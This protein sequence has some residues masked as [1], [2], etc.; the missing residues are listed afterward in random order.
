MELHFFLLQQRE[1]K[2]KNDQVCN[3]LCTL[4]KVFRISLTLPKSY[5]FTSHFFFK[6]RWEYYSKLILQIKYFVVVQSLSCVQ[7]FATPW[8]KACQALLSFTI[9][10]TSLKFMSIESLM[11]FDRPSIPNVYFSLIEDTQWG[12]NI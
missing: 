6:G 7:I 4:S 12:F 2:K 9:S 11:L 10:Q 8:I 5:M 3:I 1:G